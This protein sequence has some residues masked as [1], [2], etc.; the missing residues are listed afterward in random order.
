MMVLGLSA[1]VP[2]VLAAAA[3]PLLKLR[4]QEDYRYRVVAEG[5]VVR[6]TLLAGTVWPRTR[7]AVWP[8]TPGRVSRVLVR[9]GQSVT[10]GQVLAKMDAQRAIVELER[11]KLRL[12]RALTQSAGANEIDIQ[13]ARLEVA[14]AERSL[15]DTFLRAPISG[16]VL[17]L[18]L[19]EGE[20]IGSGGTGPPPAVIARMDDI[21]V[22]AEGDEF[23]V[24]GIR[25]G[26]KALVFFNA[27]GESGTGRVIEP[28]SLAR[29]A[30]GNSTFACIIKLDHHS[31]RNV[32]FGTS[33]RVEIEIDRR[34]GVRVVPLEA[35]VDRI[36]ERY[37]IVKREKAHE[38]VKVT[39][40][41]SNADVGELLSGP[42]TG[43][44]V[45]IAPPDV[46]KKLI[47]ER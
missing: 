45:A 11:R 28:P 10:A 34:D 27:T 12:Q 20:F 14:A 5:S 21:V 46:L 4:G 9:R 7:A 33:T 44:P 37:V 17:Q 31:P 25:S 19:R 8:A 16:S 29:F 43:T 24:G 42:N 6:S 30:P 38:A 22:E 35:I 1:I 39:I 15:D 41:L 32:V 26:Q 23:E 36:G 47:P 13:E 3:A 2:I 18:T 40:G